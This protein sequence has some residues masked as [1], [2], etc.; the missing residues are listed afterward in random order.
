M[1]DAIHRSNIPCSA[2]DTRLSHSG[3]AKASKMRSLCNV[4]ILLLGGILINLSTSLPLLLWRKE[5]LKPNYIEISKLLASLPF[6]P[7]EGLISNGLSTSSPSSF[8]SN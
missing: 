5:A 7:S 1:R 8:I 6:H 2:V 3:A 4:A